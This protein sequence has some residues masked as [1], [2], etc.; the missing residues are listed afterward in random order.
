MSVFVVCLFASFRWLLA[1]IGNWL[2]IIVERFTL[3]NHVNDLEFSL[4]HLY[5][6]LPGSVA[7]RLV[8]SKC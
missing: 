4:N 8:V 1:K 2:S 5:S 3:A 7:R 6:I